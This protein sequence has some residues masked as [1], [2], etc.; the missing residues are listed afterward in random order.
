MLCGMRNPIQP[1][2]DRPVP[3]PDCILLD[4]WW[5]D[6]RAEAEERRAL[7]RLVAADADEGARDGPRGDGRRG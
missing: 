1:S 5:A 2:P 3:L 4:A 6:T 7:L